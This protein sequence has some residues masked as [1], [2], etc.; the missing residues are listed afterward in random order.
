MPNLTKAYFDQT[1]QYYSESG[2]TLIQIDQMASAYA[3]NAAR[4]LLMD[5]PTWAH[6]AE[7]D[8]RFPARWMLQSRLFKALLAQAK[9]N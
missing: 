2:N 4:R 9:G 7:G 5:A 6:E 8:T 1:T 3:A